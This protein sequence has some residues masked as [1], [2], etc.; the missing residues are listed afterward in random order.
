MVIKEINVRSQFRFF[1]AKEPTTT[2]S[3][4]LNQFKQLL[5]QYLC[6]TATS[7]KIGEKESSSG[8]NSSKYYYFLCK[9]GSGQYAATKY[10]DINHYIKM[11]RSGLAFGV[12]FQKQQKINTYKDSSVMEVI[13]I[14]SYQIIW[15][16]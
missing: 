2:K 11:F 12:L 9:A 6:G 5:A 1:Q 10:S 15:F 4:S 7:K 3:R 16:K 13:I 14:N 8:I